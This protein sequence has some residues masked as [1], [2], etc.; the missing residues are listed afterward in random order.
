MEIDEVS[1]TLL[2]EIRNN[3]EKRVSFASVSLKTGEIYFK[4]LNTQERW[5]TGVEAAYDHVLLLHQY[6]SGT[7][8]VHKGI[9]AVDVVT[10]KTLWENFTCAFDHLCAEG[11]VIYDTRIQPRKLFL[12]DIKT[13]ENRGPKNQYIST[14]LKNNLIF[15]ETVAPGFL[16]AGLLPV[17]PF[18]NRIQYLEYNNYRIVSL[19]AIKDGAIAQYLY[20][21][22]GTDKLYEDLLNE[23]IQKLQPESFFLHK[24]HLIYIKNKC[25]LKVF[26]L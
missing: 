4:G 24:N 26:A 14:V 12:A 8:P 15:P 18:G 23:N 25:E 5:L 2:L 21:F 17:H 16:P 10:G 13:G 19:H 11:P 1:E 3:A 20:I 7:S 22:Y 9:T 6:Q